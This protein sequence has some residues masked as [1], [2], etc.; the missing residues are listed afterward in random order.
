VDTGLVEDGRL[1]VLTSADN[2]RLEKRPR[3]VTPT[4][5]DP[6]PMLDLL[7]TALER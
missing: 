6:A 3:T 7:L 5:R 4:E 2:A 1:R